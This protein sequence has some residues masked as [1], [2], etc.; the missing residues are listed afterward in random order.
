MWVTQEAVRGRGPGEMKP[1]QNAPYV[2]SY[3]HFVNCFGFVFVGLR[4]D[5]RKESSGR[6][7]GKCWMLSEILLFGVSN[8]LEGMTEAC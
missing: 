3:A 4:V 1:D 8:K 7:G 5:R 2:Y 6:G